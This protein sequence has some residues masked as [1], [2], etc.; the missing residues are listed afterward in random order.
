MSYDIFLLNFGADY[1]FTRISF[2]ELTSTR[3]F[4]HKLVQLCLK[5]YMIKNDVCEIRNRATFHPLSIQSIIQFTLQFIIHT[6]IYHSII[7]HYFPVNYNN[8]SKL[9]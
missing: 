5:T 4:K 6:P 7:S 3:S 8:S 9:H 2:I 1:G